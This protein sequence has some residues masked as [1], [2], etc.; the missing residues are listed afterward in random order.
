ML[1]RSIHEVLPFRWIRGFRH[2]VAC[3]ILR[4]RHVHTSLYNENSTSSLNVSANTRSYFNT[5]H[6]ITS[7]LISHNIEKALLLQL[8]MPLSLLNSAHWYVVGK[9]R[10]CVSVCVLW[11]L[12]WLGERSGTDACTW[13]S[14]FASYFSQRLSFEYRCF[15]HMLNW[16]TA[17]MWFASGLGFMFLCAPRLLFIRGIDDDFTKFTSA[18]SFNDCVKIANC[19]TWRKSFFTFKAIRDSMNLESCFCSLWQE[20]KKF[21]S[22]SEI[23]FTSF[24]W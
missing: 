6:T 7:T 18:I 1:I 15:V 9:R 16:F 3:L 20:L 2:L 13:F 11:N 8:S 5:Y 22:H 19:F 12:A 24:W 17:M 4:S 21:L 23:G 14:S 10:G